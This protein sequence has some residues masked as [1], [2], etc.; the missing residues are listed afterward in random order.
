MTA[1]EL[2]E[3]F[4]VSTRTIYRDVDVLSLA[5]IPVYTEKGK[6]GG[7]SLM[8]DYV[9]NKSIL[10]E[11]EQDEILNA[12]KS[13]SLIGD[14]EAGQ[15]LR[16]LSAIFNKTAANWLEVDFSG[17]NYNNEDVFG[18]FKTA[19][20]E[21]RITKF[22]YYSAYGELTHRQVEPLQL[23]FKSKAWYLKGFCLTKQDVRMFKLIRANN[24]VVT[25]ET[26]GERDLLATQPNPCPESRHKPDVCLRLHI[27]PEMA[28]RV[29]DELDWSA[30]EKQPDGSYIA[31]VTWPEDNWVY[32]FILSLGE[33]VEVLEPEYIKEIIKTKAEKIFCKYL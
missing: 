31:T 26:F 29:Y 25:N 5:G 15:V 13:Q 30:V 23:W 19:I 32:G 6:N 16:R 2:A 24:L 21:S 10:S 27:A 33:Y 9:L 17:W 14:G 3:R 12:L 8:P 4:N 11:G 7:I 20:L 22:D 28:Y 18:G 1:K